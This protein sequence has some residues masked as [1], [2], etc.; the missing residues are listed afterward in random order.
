MEPTVGSKQIQVDQAVGMCGKDRSPRV[1]ALRHMV[2]HTKSHDASQTSH[3]A[4][5]FRGRLISRETLRL[6][7][8][9]VPVAALF[10]VLIWL[11]VSGRLWWRSNKFVFTTDGKPGSAL[12]VGPEAW[13]VVPKRDSHDAYVVYPKRQLLGVAVTGRF[14]YLPSCV[15][16]LDKPATYIPMP[17]MEVPF[18]VSFAEHQ[19]TFKGTGGEQVVIR[20]ASW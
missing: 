18:S 17:K 1:A 10:A 3:N 16:S 6:S 15:L 14:V 8:G 11:S 19:V 20:E 2:R 12:Y 4:G 7:P 13:L 5:V 9:F